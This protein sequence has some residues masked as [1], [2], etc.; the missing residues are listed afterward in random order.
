M[1]I[2]EI[3]DRLVVLCRAAD[4]DTAQRELFS[5]DAISIE[6]RE[7]PAFKKETRG[8][9]SIIE[10]NKKFEEMTAQLHGVKISEPILAENSFAMRMDMDITMK[11]RPRSTFTELCVYRVK[12]GKIISEQFFE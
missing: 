5:Q 2:K 11:E 8:L 1:T 6:P 10:K 7:T 4:F 12:D 3:A 9:N